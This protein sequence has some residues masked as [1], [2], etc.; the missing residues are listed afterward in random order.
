MSCFYRN[1]L[2]GSQQVVDVAQQFAGS[3]VRRY[4][5]VLKGF[6]SSENTCPV[7]EIDRTEIH[8]QCGNGIVAQCLLEKF[9]VRNFM[10]ADVGK[11]SGLR[12]RDPRE[13]R[14]NDLRVESSFQL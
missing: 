4:A 5:Q 7:G 14:R 9:A 13:R 3:I 1:D 8:L 2:S 12:C 6:G 11:I 10:V